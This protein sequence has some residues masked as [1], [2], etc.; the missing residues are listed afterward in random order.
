MFEVKKNL[1]ENWERIVKAWTSGL[2][3]ERW[4][5]LLPLLPGR[6]C[7]LSMVFRST[8]SISPTLGD[9]GI[10]SV[11]ILGFCLTNLFVRIAFHGA[12]VIPVAC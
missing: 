10:L 7:V 4:R 3:S 8:C 11:F 9:P 5:D 6:F 1:W 2:Q 12:E